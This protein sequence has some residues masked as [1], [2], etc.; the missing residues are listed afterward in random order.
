MKK[1]LFLICGFAALLYADVRVRMVYH[2][3]DRY[4]HGSVQPG[5]TLEQTLWV[6]EN[7]L[8]WIHPEYI[9]YEGDQIESPA[10]LCWDMAQQKIIFINENDSS[11][12]FLAMN[13]DRSI[14]LSEAAREFLDNLRVTRSCTQTDSTDTVL[15]TVCT[16]MR[17]QEINSYGG[18]RFYDRERLAAVSTEVPFEWSLYTDMQNWVYAIFLPSGTLQECQTRGFLLASRDTRYSQGQ[19]II[20]DYTT[21]A[22]DT[23]PAPAGIYDIPAETNKKEKLDRSD[24]L[25]LRRMIFISGG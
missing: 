6:G 3:P 10:R 17:M 11:A 2:F 19:S 18:E 22:I 7:R 1:C 16:I 13:D 4:H 12:T 20:S 23:L 5:Y 21:A 14:F 15:N 25:I 9:N 24:I 8:A